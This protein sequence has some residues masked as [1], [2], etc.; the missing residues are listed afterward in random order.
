MRVNRRFLF[1]G[2]FL[3]AVG[4]VLVAVDLGAIDPA[5][6][7][8]VLLLWPVA[9][10]AI[11]VGIV[12][13]RTQLGLP[14]GMV[15]AAA[16]GLLL[17]GALAV[18][19]RLAANCGG[20]G[21]VAS[22]PIQQGT[23]DGPA[24]V[25]ISSGCGSLTIS[26]ASGNGWQLQAANSSGKVPTVHGSSRSLSIDQVGE[27]EYN[28]LTGGRETWDVSLPAGD[29]DSLSIEVATSR[30]RVALPGARVGRLA[31]S[32]N[33]SEMTVDASGAS[34]ASLSATVNLGQ[35]SLTLPANSDLVGSLRVGG[36]RLEVC[37]SPGVGLR[38]TDTGFPRQLEI[39]GVDHGASE[40]Q[41]PDYA[42]ATHHAD[43]TV[44][45]TVG[46]VQI[47]PIGGCR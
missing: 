8:Q 2:V 20:R 5:N 33:A 40:W 29:I 19:P 3:V 47:N 14:A 31:L 43:L 13:R 10:L 38:I 4:G 36:G 22:L 21:D 7:E 44:H 24:D 27:D 32:A 28:F 42:S 15:A 35:L 16:P 23:F 12:S 11:G 1:S 39:A 46:E 45:T 34:V 17:G 37:T 9:V 18:G 25:S 30:S 41:S 26:T 6:L